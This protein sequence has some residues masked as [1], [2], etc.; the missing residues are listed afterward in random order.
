MKRRAKVT[1]R[2]LFL[3]LALLVVA[4]LAGLVPLHIEVFSKTIAE[5]VRESTGLDLELH[6]PVVMQLGPRAG[7][8]ASRV[9]LYM[10]AGDALLE[11]DEGRVGVSLLALAAGRIH[12]REIEV[13]GL[14]LDI[15]RPLPERPE[16]PVGPPGEPPTVV[17]DGLDVSDIELLCA[18]EFAELRIDRLAAAAPAGGPIEIEASASVAGNETS[19]TAT[20]GTLTQL[21]GKQAFPFDAQIK[22]DTGAVR[23][24][25]VFAWEAGRPLVDARV[26]L[27]VA[28]VQSLGEAFD[29]SAPD[30][31]AV[32]LETGIRVD[33]S[34][35][36]VQDLTAAVGETRISASGRVDLA[37]DRPAVEL[38][39]SLQTLDLAPF[40]STESGSN[41]ELADFTSLFDVLQQFDMRASVGIERVVGLPVDIR[42]ASFEA[43]LAGGLVELRSG[44]A[45]LLDGRVALSGKLDAT[46][47]CPSLDLVA[48]VDGVALTRL[49]DAGWLALAVDGRITSARVESSSCG[50]NVAGLLEQLSVSAK[51]AGGRVVLA[52]EF[53]VD[54]GRVNVSL[55]PDQ[56]VKASVFATF[57]G[58]SLEIE[59]SA[60]PLQ[61]LD[62]VDPW[63]VSLVARAAG[64]ELHTTGTAGFATPAFDL[65]ASLS[66]SRIGLLHRW[67]GISP[68]VEGGLRATTRLRLDA[69][70]LVADDIDI[71]LNGTDMSG[72]FTWL[73]AATPDT[74][75]VKLRS[76]F[77]DLDKILR[78]IDEAGPPV[79]ETDGQTRQAKGLAAWSGL[80]PVDLDLAFAAIRGGPVDVTDLIIDGHLD[81]GLVDNAR[82]SALVEDELSL[83]GQLDADLRQ[84]PATLVFDAEAGNADLGR[85]LR[86]LDLVEDL[87]MR[88]DSFVLRAESS[89]DSP[90]TALENL[91]VDATVNR[92]AWDVPRRRSDTDF[93]VRLDAVALSMRPGE[94][95]GASTIGMVDGVQLELWLQLPGLGAVLG[96]SPE[97]PLRVV[98]AA[99]NDVAMIDL[100]LDRTA[101]DE[102]RG[103]IELSGQVLDAGER[104]LA[105]LDAPLGGYALTG[106][107]QASR[108]AVTLSDFAARLGSSEVSGQVSLSGDGRQR[109][110]I[111]L[112]SPHLQ[113]DDWTYL[114][115]FGRERLRTSTVTAV[116]E[117]PAEAAAS[118][119]PRKGPLLVINELIA[120]YQEHYDLDL[121]VSIDE[122]YAGQDLVGG[123]EV[124][125]HIDEQNFRLQP[126]TIRLPGGSLDAEYGWLNYDGRVEAGLK[127]HADGLV[128]GGLVRLV[129]PELDARG[130]LYVD[131]DFQAESAWSADRS[132]FD[133]LLSNA[134]GTV[135]IA[136]WPQ[137][138]EAD[139]LDLWTAN[140][141]FALLPSPI[142]G[143]T[144]RLNCVVAR[145][146][147]K[148]GLLK[149]KNV[150]MDSTGTII[151]GRGRI[152]LNQREIDLL[153][154]PQAKR[155]RFFSA[156]TPVRVTG[157]LDDFEVGVEPAGFLGTLIRWYTSLIYVP[158]KWLTGQRFPADGTQT[159]FDAMDWEL[160]PELEAYFRER[161]FSAP[162]VV[163]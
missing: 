153:V 139:I 132:E 58:E 59:A 67:L 90:R 28:D 110:V 95:L 99:D 75:A 53:A 57:Q 51:I 30:I 150:L 85:L 13:S 149:T 127:A 120:R 121:N 41:T 18:G 36:E 134:D 93:E 49:H 100:L 78:T 56:P 50:T 60:G 96:D 79:A 33:L 23:A 129:D 128:Y 40:T 92:F 37:D 66:V 98:A 156:S 74:L 20:G 104:N 73:H 155:E 133:L 72:E 142:D 124:E 160:T 107:L 115:S 7:I 82:V 125:L 46:Q 111:D 88:A 136:V 123:A 47:D 145:L 102:I 22:M 81:A 87:T 84:S 94:P 34:R 48:D 157:P 86:R 158:F 5:S 76:D 29:V 108:A 126:V 103:R 152:D 43:A 140:L 163:K 130:L 15:C 106:N 80:P 122:L 117:A 112:S 38:T 101:E 114:P 119:P 97:L 68:D 32:D 12:L 31:G 70:R 159:C 19:V 3:G 138:F 64:S 71:A 77:V 45:A 2:V 148:D 4:A 146:E 54:I 52:E 162:P 35:L 8:T 10:P 62:G 143:E 147:A 63:P 105:G 21:L 25:G 154:T 161:D 27:N 89:G 55:K 11:L 1:L 118:Q 116:A 135:D 42:A 9:A 141:V 137:N 113:A 65:K 6:G 16:A 69:S 109:L 151:R 26:G 14:R 24:E 44:E 131:V 61:A 91:R 39:A 144:S 17:I 83:R